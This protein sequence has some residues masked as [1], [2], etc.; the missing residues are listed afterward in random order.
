[1]SSYFVVKTKASV[2]FFE[3][4]WALKKTTGILKKKQYKK[5]LRF[6]DLTSK[7]VQT[8]IILRNLFSL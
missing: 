1:M 8:F 5:V 4:F 7:S 3:E 2:I 6:T